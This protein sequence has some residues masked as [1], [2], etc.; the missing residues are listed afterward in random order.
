VREVLPGN[1]DLPGYTWDFT[2]HEG[3]NR[4]RVRDLGQPLEP[5]GRGA[6]SLELGD[7]LDAGVDAGGASQPAI[8]GEERGV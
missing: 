8:A 1:H 7:E 3:P 5:L 2:Q 6:R 4:M